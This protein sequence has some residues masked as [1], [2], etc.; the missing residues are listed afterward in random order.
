MKSNNLSYIKILSE[1]LNIAMK[2]GMGSNAANRN[3]S[4]QKTVNSNNNQH[5]TFS[6][7]STVHI[8][9]W[10]IWDLFT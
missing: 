5:S 9:L 4:R 8:K 2:R 10:I 1:R 3:D 7:N 6:K